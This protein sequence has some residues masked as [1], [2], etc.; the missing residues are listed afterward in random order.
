MPLPPLL[1][2]CA[3]ADAAFA[4]LL[5]RCLRHF[6]MLILLNFRY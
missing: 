5:R 6:A 2:A 3:A 4:M 1:Y